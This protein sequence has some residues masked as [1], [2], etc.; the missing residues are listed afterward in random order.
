MKKN[1]Y[2][3]FYI[4]NCILFSPSMVLSIYIFFILF[5][6]RK[7]TY[8]S[9]WFIY[10]DNTCSF[11]M[12]TVFCWRLGWNGFFF[13]SL[14]IYIYIYSSIPLY[15]YYLFY[16]FFYLLFLRSAITTWGHK[17]RLKILSFKFLASSHKSRQ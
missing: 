3:I 10:Y 16:N 11:M 5:A 15:C 9:S 7:M 12:L 1:L 14:N 2:I 13:C 8:A 6:Q 17:I 4:K